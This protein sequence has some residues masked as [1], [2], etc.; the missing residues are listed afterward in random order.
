VIQV[1]RTTK[2][3]YAEV[4]FDGEGARQAGGRFNRRG[5]PVVYTSGTLSLSVL[6][7]LTQL[8]GYEDLLDY[9]SIPTRF[10]PRHVKALEIPDLPED[11]RS[12]PP[13]QSTKVL[14]TA[15]A[16]SRETLVLR[17]PSVVLPAEHNYLINPLHPDMERVEMGE[18][19]D[20][21]IDPRLVKG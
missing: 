10:D 12:L 21:D 16:T 9:V 20:L 7:V 4:A 19:E 14:G 11:W 15:W 18:P 2:R 8:V 6:E 5:I 1:W 3:K 17:V 13:P